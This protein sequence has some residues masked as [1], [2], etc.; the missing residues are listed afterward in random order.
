MVQICII[1]LMKITKAKLATFVKHQLGTNP[2]WATRALIRIFRE[3]QTVTEQSTGVTSADNGIGF[4]GIDSV[5]LSSF[6]AQF[7]RHGGLSEKQINLLLKKMPK[8]HKQVI[9]MSDEA[10]LQ[11]AYEKEKAAHLDMVQD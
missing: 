9:A 1:V 7:E 11:A 3:N 4:N 2:A 6:A 8:Y 5:I 10:K